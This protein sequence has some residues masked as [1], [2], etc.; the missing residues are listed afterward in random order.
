[1]RLSSEDISGTARDGL[2]SGL[3]SFIEVEVILDASGKAHE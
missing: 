3:A 2:N 1:M